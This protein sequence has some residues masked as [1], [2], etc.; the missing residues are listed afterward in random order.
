MKIIIRPAPGLILRKLQTH[1]VARTIVQAN[2]G[3]PTCKGDDF[4]IRLRPGSNI[5]IVSTP[6]EG[7][8]HGIDVGTSEEELMANLRVRTNGVRILRARMLGQSQTALLH[9]EGPRCLNFCTSTE[10]RCLAETASRQ[11]SSAPSAE[12]PDIHQT[13]AP[14]QRFARAIRATSLTQKPDHTCVPKCALCGGAHL[15]AAKGCNNN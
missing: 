15:T 2:G 12:P 11:G 10:G 3:A 7:V 14:T 1:Q 6:H 5:I 4:I 9:F 8:V 13:S